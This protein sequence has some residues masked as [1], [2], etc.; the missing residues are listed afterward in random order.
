MISQVKIVALLLLFLLF[1][2]TGGHG[3]L[4]FLHSTSE[5]AFNTDRSFSPRV[6]G[7]SSFTWED[8]FF[9]ESLID[10]EKSYNYFVDKE[11]G[12]VLMANTYSAWYN[13]QWAFMKPIN[14]TNPTSETFEE[15]VLN[16]TVYYDAGMQQDYR[17]LRFVDTEGNNLYYWRGEY[18]PGESANVL[19]RIPQLPA[20]STTTIYM[21]Y[22][23][24]TAD[25]YSNF[26]MIFTWDDRTDPDLLISY[27]YYT[28]GAWDPD[29]AFGNDRFLIA[30][31]EGLGPED[32]TL[33]GDR[34][35]YRQ[36][37]G[38]TYDHDGQ[39]PSPPPSSDM[40]IYISSI[41]DDFS[42][43]AENPSIAYGN[44][45]FFIVWEENPA[46]P[47]Y[48]Q[49]RYEVDIKGAILS[50]EGSILD[51]FTIC[52]AINGQYDP[53]VTYGNNRFFV[54]WE[55]AR[56]GATN[57]DVYG[58]LYDT[59]GNSLGPD[60]QVAGGANYQ[61]EPWICSG[62]NGYFMV[63][64]EEGDNPETGPF[65]LYAQRY[66]S[67][68]NKAGSR[69]GIALGS[70]DLDY[71]LPSVAFCSQT[72]R[73][74][75]SWNDGDLSVDPSLRSS[76]DGNIWGKIIDQ[77]GSIVADNFIIQPGDQYIRSDV[78]PYLD[79]LFFVSYDGSSDLWGR[80]VSSDGKITTSEH[81]LS[82][83]SSQSV[84]WNNLAV[85]NG[86]LFAVWEDERDMASEHADTFG[87]VWH[88]YRSTGSPHITYNMGDEKELITRTVLISQIIAPGT[89]F[90][91][92]ETF[93]ASYSTPLGHIRFG[94]LNQGGTQILLDSINPGKDIS[95]LP[96]QAIRLQAT[97]TRNIAIQTPRLDKWSVS[98]IGE[99]YDPPWTDYEMIPSLPTGNNGW[100]TQSVE[101]IF[102]PH[103]DV[104]PPSDLLTYYTINHG[105]TQIY[106]PSQTPKI[107][108]E[109]QDNTIEFWSV[110]KA[111][112]EEIPHTT[113]ENIKID[114]TPPTVTI[115]SPEWG[116]VTQGDIQVS[117]TL[118]DTG[119]GVNEVQ[120]WFNGGLIN[121]NLVDISPAKDYF[122]WHFTAEK[123]QQYDI[124]VRAYDTA[125][126]VGKGYVSVRC[127]K[128]T[129]DIQVATIPLSQE[130]TSEISPL[131][132]ISG[133]TQPHSQ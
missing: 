91:E 96:H 24:P 30:W 11:N 32:I 122:E 2:A 86:H 100:Y 59:M 116:K 49:N 45:V 77:Y 105:E 58:R 118:A 10:K 107:S 99:D 112:N 94:I 132:Y 7:Q 48:P 83:G 121:E 5:T 66:D 108:S 16:L 61:G 43:H 15:Y 12:E 56:D 103:D 44:N 22:G 124:E 63:A 81:M 98:W 113:V 54:V 19:V 79:T 39:N 9:D 71:I 95:S 33:D 102:Y 57:Y 36:I 76:W 47:T 92:W 35:F 101:F 52:E 14:I 20:L 90:L 126:H 46:T 4:S 53:I 119:S 117:G 75:F 37:H 3:L 128:I 28:E 88:I 60:F 27:K 42:Y 80:L 38:R 72:N 6:M 26:D 131:P 110:D 111:G 68:G 93:D 106:N 55:D 23:D 17:D 104:T 120:V 123:W 74:L 67:S 25:D 109:G 13:P 41:P 62:N 8:D 50:S 69:L 114:P 40:D 97:F 133:R 21:F 64:Y 51:R 89:G 87:S 82:D 115:E 84:D 70:P 127:T 65:S 1:G 130:H 29:V 73:Y 34:L 31:E 78:V 18:V 85:G 125:G 129:Q